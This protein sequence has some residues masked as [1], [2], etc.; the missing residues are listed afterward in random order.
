MD[1]IRLFLWFALLGSLWLTYSTWVAEHAPLE[2][3]PAVVA[4]GAADQPPPGDDTPLPQLEDGSANPGSSLAAPPV[5]SAAAAPSMPV[6][7][8]TDVLDIVIDTQGGDIVRVDL[9]TYPV[10]KDEPDRVVRLLDYSPDTRWVLQSGVRNANGGPEANH[11]ATFQSARS[12]YALE[13]GADE[14]KVELAWAESGATR[15]TKVYTFHRGSF[16]INLDTVITNGT[17]EPWRGAVYTQMVR[18]HKPLK[19]SYASIDS[20][21]FTGPVLYDGDSYEKLDVEELLTQPTTQTLADGWYA[22][23]QHHFLAGVVPPPTEETRYQATARGQDYVLTALSPI[24]EIAPGA[25]FD[26]PV[27]LFIGPKIQEQLRA[28]ADEMELTVDY[29]VLTPLAQP[30]FWIL[31]HIH[32]WV[33]NWGWAI[34]IC[35]MLIKL[36]FYKLTATSGRSMA[37]MRKLAPR[38]KSLQE[39]YKDDRQG[40]SQAMMDLYKR[41]KVNPAAGCLPILIQ[42]PFFFAFYWVLIESVEMRQAPFMLW[43]ND[44]SVRD[45]FFVLPVLMGAAMLFQMRLNP[46]PPDPVQARVMQIMP[47]VFTGMFALFPAGL[48]L[49]WLTN[50]LLSILQQWRINTLVARES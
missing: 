28:T 37:K 4:P 1:N 43:I 34:I 17:G 25:E 29:G 18:L 48:V 13:G 40:L 39:R 16:E 10:E 15:V 44:L 5:E 49:Y 14:L 31:S 47:I 11:L 19:R 50:T 46:A 32:D 30:L 41:E 26:Y 36:A 7:V 38:M 42:M 22:G 45:P 2:P 3:R 35:T 20:Y 33:G 23:I 12:E 8:R 9:P 21:S 6:H 27:R 24:E